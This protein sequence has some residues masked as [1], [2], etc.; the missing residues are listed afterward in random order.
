[1]PSLESREYL[2]VK[3]LQTALLAIST[4]AGY[5]ATLPPLAVRLDPENDIESLIAETRARAGTVDRSFALLSFPSDAFDYGA[6]AGAEHGHV[7]IAMPFNVSWVQRI[8]PA[9]DDVRLQTLYRIFADVETALEPRALLR[10]LSGLATDVRILSRT[11]INPN[12]SEIWAV[13]TGTVRIK[14]AYGA[15][16]KQ[17]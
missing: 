17:V 6:A 9:S 3:A 16:N 14:R 5:H 2:I 11:D 8:D 7:V 4:A 1:M 15:P 10:E 12:S 13:L